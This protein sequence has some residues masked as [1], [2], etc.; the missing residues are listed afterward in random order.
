MI[1]KYQRVELFIILL[2]KTCVVSLVLKQSCER[3][4]HPYFYRHNKWYILAILYSDSL[5]GFIL[6]EI[7]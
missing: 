6:W 3:V 5:T 7:E 1:T 2:V 4:V